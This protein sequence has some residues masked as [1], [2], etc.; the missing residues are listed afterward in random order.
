MTSILQKSIDDLEDGD[1][2]KNLPMYRQN[3]DKVLSIADKLKALGKRHNNATAGQIALAW[4]LTRG[5]NVMVIPGTKK[6]K[7]R[8]L[9]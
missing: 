1:F 6:I 7:V 9:K 2:R 3:F 8:P 4:L 5:D